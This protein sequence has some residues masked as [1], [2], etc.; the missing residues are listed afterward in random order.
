MAKKN[1]QPKTGTF[2][3]TGLTGAEMEV[4]AAALGTYRTRVLASHEEV[5]RTDSRLRV[6]LRERAELALALK[7]VIE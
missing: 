1:H 6:N 3:L 2:S 5:P 4:L 7:S